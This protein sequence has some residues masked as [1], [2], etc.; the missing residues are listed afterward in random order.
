MKANSLIFILGFIV[1]LGIG[2]FVFDDGGEK[3]AEES[4]SASTEVADEAATSEETTDEEGGGETVASSEA[5]ALENN[6][7]LSCH[8]VEALGASGGT[9]GPDLSNAYTDVEGKHGK[10]LDEFLIEPTSAVMTTVINEDNPLPDEERE[11]IIEALKVASE[12]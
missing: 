2:Y 6:N 1:A 9:T 4:D 12:K 10:P 11:A 7:C 8:S 5:E 3:Q